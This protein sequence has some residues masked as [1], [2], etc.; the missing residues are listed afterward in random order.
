MGDMRYWGIFVLKLAG[1]WALVRGIWEL[2]QILMPPPATFLY[3]QFRPF[4]RDLTWTVAIL[5]LFLFAC[6]LLYTAIY[7]QHFRCRSCGRRLRMPV[8][9]GSYSQMLQEGRPQFEYICAFGHGTL[10]VPGT[11]FQGREPSRWQA[12]KGLWEH[13]IAADRGR[14]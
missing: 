10:S 1:I 3:Y 4:G 2:F 7:D 9:R 14:L 5:L 8:L 13:L 6:G 12:N 11:K